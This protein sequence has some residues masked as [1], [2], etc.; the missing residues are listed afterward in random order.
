MWSQIIAQM[1]NTRIHYGI[2]LLFCI[3]KYR[4]AIDFVAF[5][6]IYATLFDTAFMWI[7]SRSGYEVLQE[8]L[9]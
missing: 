2:C 5:V 1:P 7:S 9:A 3:L 4:L 6:W 8:S